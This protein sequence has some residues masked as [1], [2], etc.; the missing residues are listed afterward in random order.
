M[1]RAPGTRADTWV[2]GLGYLRLVSATDKDLR[3]DR[4]RRVG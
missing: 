4:D 3:S 1:M 2:L